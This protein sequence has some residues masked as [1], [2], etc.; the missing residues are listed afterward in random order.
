MGTIGFISTIGFIGT[1]GFISTIGLI[2]TIGFLGI[3]ATIKCKNYESS[4]ILLVKKITYLPP[5]Q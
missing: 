2:G 5:G 1:I 4:D 3:M